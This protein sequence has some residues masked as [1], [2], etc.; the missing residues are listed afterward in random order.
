MQN[1]LK[2]VVEEA[3]AGRAQNIKAKTIGMDVHGYS[4]DEISD[5]EG[6]VRVDAGRVRR[7]LAKY[8]AEEGQSDAIKIYLPT[9][10]YAPE[11]SRNASEETAEEVPSKP[12]LGIAAISVVVPIIAVGI[13]MA[14]R[15]THDLPPPSITSID[16]SE[17]FDISPNR[18]EAINLAVKARGLIFPATDAQ[19]LSIALQ[20]FQ[21]S[22]GKDNVYF[23]GY[24]G[25]AQVLASLALIDPDR[26]RAKKNLALAAQNG[27][28]ATRLAP[29]EA[30][31]LSAQ[32]WVEFA[33]R[34]HGSA[35]ELSQRAV[36]LA[37]LD[38]HILEFD[39]LI[40]LF[41]GRF[42]HILDTATQLPVSAKSVQGFVY[43]NAIGS[44]QYHTGD[45]DSAIHSLEQAIAA[46][47]PFGPISLTYLTAAYQRAGDTENAKYLA[48]VMMKNW[49]QARPD[50]L[51]FALFSDPAPAQ[52]LL[53]AITAAGWRVQN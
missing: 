41:N 12:R 14:G 50:L 11:F 46:Q 40:S 32:A 39:F 8:Y 49:P 28:E 5:R 7:K 47:G 30:W 15:A 29:D 17:I 33:V 16:H 31:S 10:R 25:A 9:G 4:P 36:A 13:W 42:Q 3:L 48:S 34:N 53:D 20:A 44:A 38:P 26:E 51:F 22:I 1:F 23:G 43:S 37:P 19:R 45:Y 2:Y 6:V 52:D 27:K 21:I 18:V 35:L 24:A